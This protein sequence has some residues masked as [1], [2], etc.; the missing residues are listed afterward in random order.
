[1][2]EL[3]IA[4]SDDDLTIVVANEVGTLRYRMSEAEREA[5]DESGR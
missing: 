1:V 2:I 3:G 4:G 5:P